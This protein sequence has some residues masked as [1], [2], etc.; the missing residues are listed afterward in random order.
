V[1][2]ACIAAVAAQDKGQ[3][4]QHPHKTS[5][6]LYRE[7]RRRVAPARRPERGEASGVKISNLSIKRMHVMDIV[8]PYI[9]RFPTSEFVNLK[10]TPNVRPDTDKSVVIKYKGG[11]GTLKY[12]DTAPVP[13]VIKRANVYFGELETKQGNLYVHL[14]GQWKEAGTRPKD[15]MVQESNDLVATVVEIPYPSGLKTDF[16]FIPHDNGKNDLED[17]ENNDNLYIVN[18][19]VDGTQLQLQPRKKDK[20]Y[21]TLNIFT[22]IQS[23]QLPPRGKE[24]DSPSLNIWD[25]IRSVQEIVKRCTTNVNLNGQFKFEILNSDLKKFNGWLRENK[26]FVNITLEIQNEHQFNIGTFHGTDSAYSYTW[27]RQ[28]WTGCNIEK[29]SKMKFKNVQEEVSIER[30]KEEKKVENEKKNTGWGWWRWPVKTQECL[31]LEMVDDV[32]PWNGS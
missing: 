25:D 10:F 32:R 3:H 4:R 11:L 31:N 14:L 29:S 28:N 13:M 9:V 17:L 24:K 7:S 26:I 18:E 20:D 2:V 15:S 6:P 1:V 16:V 21:P 27:L 19:L 5:S 22:D 8:N 12:N 23:V 30:L